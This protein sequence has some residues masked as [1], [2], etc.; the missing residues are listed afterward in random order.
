MTSF[1]KLDTYILHRTKA[2][3]STKL[4]QFKALLR[5]LRPCIR[6]ISRLSF[7]SRKSYGKDGL[8]IGTLDLNS[9]VDSLCESFH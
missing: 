8:I 9:C 3:V 5:L 4:G 6:S 1:T 2:I 7:L